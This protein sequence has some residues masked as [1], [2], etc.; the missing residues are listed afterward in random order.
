MIFWNWQKPS[1]AFRIMCWIITAQLA[2]HWTGNSFL[3]VS[4]TL[5]M[6][7]T[8]LE[9]KWNTLIAKKPG[10]NEWLYIHSI[11]LFFDWQYSRPWSVLLSTEI[12]NTL[13]FRW[14]LGHCNP[15]YLPTERGFDSHLGYWMALEGYYDKISQRGYD[16]HEGLDPVTNPLAREIYSTVSCLLEWHKKSAVCYIF[17]FGT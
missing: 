6:Q 10:I 11:C 13:F 7:R 5:V 12:S 15:A 4:R 1:F 14:H 17:M 3:T 8:L 16:F 2:S 9:S